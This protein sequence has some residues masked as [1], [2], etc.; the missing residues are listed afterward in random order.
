ML[1]RLRKG[2]AGRGPAA[3]AA[4]SVDKSEFG[5]PPPGPSH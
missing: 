3:A 5:V 2:V 1:A 4:E